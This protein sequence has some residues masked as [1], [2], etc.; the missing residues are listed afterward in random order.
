MDQITEFS[1]NAFKVHK[2]VWS[3]SGMMTDLRRPARYTPSRSIE[4]KGHTVALKATRRWKSSGTRSGECIAI[5]PDGTRVPMHAT[6]SRNVAPRARV[7]S[8]RESHAEVNA[9]IRA[10]IGATNERNPDA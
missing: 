3:Y 4:R 9:R 5:F 8:D 2:E 10:R 6:R 7:I 1:E